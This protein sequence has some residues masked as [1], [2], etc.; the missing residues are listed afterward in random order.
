MLLFLEVII[1]RLKNPTF[2]ISPMVVFAFLQFHKFWFIFRLFSLSLF[3]FCFRFIFL[4]FM[5]Y[6]RKY[7]ETVLINRNRF[8][9]WR[10]WFLGSLKFE[11]A[12]SVFSLRHF[13]AFGR[14]FYPSKTKSLSMDEWWF[15]TCSG[16]ALFIIYTFHARGSFFKIIQYCISLKRYCFLLLFSNI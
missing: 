3:S 8:L 13:L 14:L 10:N 1:T 15:H 9:S 11:N 2:N 12:A 16:W 6:R 7:S 5:T 4:Y